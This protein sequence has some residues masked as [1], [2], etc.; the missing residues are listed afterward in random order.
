MNEQSISF[1]FIPGSRL[2][3]PYIFF[4]LLT[5][6]LPLLSQVFIISIF[7]CTGS[8]PSCTH[9]SLNTSGFFV[10]LTPPQHISSGFIVLLW[11]LLLLFFALSPC[12]N[13]FSFCKFCLFSLNYGSYSILLFAFWSCS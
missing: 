7:P 3:S 6:S 12:F 4:F 9:L 11:F 10:T 5:F 2:S 13:V 1:C 8:F